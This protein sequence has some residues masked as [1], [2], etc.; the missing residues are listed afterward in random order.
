MIGNVIQSKFLVVTDY[1][2]AAALSF[3]LM[4]ILLVLVLAY[5]KVLGRRNLEEAV[6]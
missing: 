5:T 2:E 6:I 3:I 4:A 1:P